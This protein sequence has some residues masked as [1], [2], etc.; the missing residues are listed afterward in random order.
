MTIT[1]QALPL[2]E[3]AEP[4]QVRR[5]TLHLTDQWSMWMQDGCKVYMDSY[6][7]SNRSWSMVTWIVFQKTPLGGRPNTKLGYDGTLNAHNS[8]YILFHHMWIPVWTDFHWNSIGLRTLSHNMTSRFTW[9]SV[10]T[11]HDVGGILGRPLDTFFWA[12]MI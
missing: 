8:W 9:G 2:V 4:V 11:L 1:L 5:F 12:L 10:T 6:M 7:A 3:N